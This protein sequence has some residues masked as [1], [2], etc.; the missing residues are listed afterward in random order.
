M[1]RR[2]LCQSPALIWRG[3]FSFPR[4]C[5][6]KASAS[7]VPGGITQGGNMSYVKGLRCR[8]CG[9]EYAK[10]PVAGCEDC[11]APLE[12][13]Y[14]YD[15]IKLKLNRETIKSREKNL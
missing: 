11:F 4:A 9:R 14:D 1:A 3:A 13:D 10:Q 8:E 6:C 12:I 15:A 2:I 5:A 7:C